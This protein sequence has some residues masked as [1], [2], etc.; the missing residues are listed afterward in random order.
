MRKIFLA[1]HVFIYFQVS[2]QSL[3]K[4]EMR[5]EGEGRNYMESIF[6]LKDYSISYLK[7]ISVDDNVVNTGKQIDEMDL[8]S[9]K[10]LKISKDK[11][12][13]PKDCNLDFNI[14]RDYKN[15]V[16]YRFKPNYE[17]FGKSKIDLALIKD[18][19]NN[20]Q[21]K[22]MEEF[23]TINSLRCQHAIIN[24]RCQEYDAWMC[25]EIA[26]HTGPF[27]FSESPGLIVKLSR[28]DD[29]VTWNLKEFNPSVSF[30]EIRVDTLLAGIADCNPRSFC[31]LK[32]GFEAFLKKLRA[33][34]GDEDC[35][36]CE[37]KLTN[38]KIDECFDGCP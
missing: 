37:S 17:N 26:I 16:I 23:D 18:T 15:K 34:V 6:V 30:E 29:G 13:V 10:S 20:M 7:S 4:Y 24:F 1:F 22:L 12:E 19:I 27:I 38:I 33:Y 5:N 28:K 8:A 36:T 14:L 21:W 3:I 31:D 32:K 35:L 2:S 25:M 9:Q 11:T